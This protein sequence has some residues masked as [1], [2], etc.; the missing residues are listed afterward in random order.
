M[1]YRLV[2]IY[3][4]S[5]IF[6]YNYQVVAYSESEDFGWSSVLPRKYTFIYAMLF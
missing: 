6:F 1:A 4:F 5:S 2:T 3:M